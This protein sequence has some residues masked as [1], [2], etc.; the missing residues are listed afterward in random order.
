MR[1]RTRTKRVGAKPARARGEGRIVI[2]ECNAVFPPAG[3]ADS[4]A[5]ARASAVA[6]PAEGTARAWWPPGGAGTRTRTTR[7]AR[8]GA[9]L[10]RVRGEGRIGSRSCQCS[11]LAWC[12]PYVNIL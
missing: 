9:K 10:A 6:A 11:P 2:R 3:A 4:A 8:V 1:T 7:V 5:R 12:K